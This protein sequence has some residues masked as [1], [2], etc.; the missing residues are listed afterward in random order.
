[1]DRCAQCGA[2][3]DQPE[4]GR[5]RRYC[6]RSCQARAY[7]ARSAARPT[8]RIARPRELTPARIAAAAVALADRTGFEGL[9]MRRLATELGIATMGLYRHFPS[10]D[11][12][13]VAMTDAVLDEVRP[14]G[15]HLTGWRPRL[16]H[17][18]R[19]E[20]ALYRRHPWVLPAIARSRP[21]VGRGLLASVDRILSGI[22][23]LGVGP[24]RLLSVYLAVSGLVQGLALLPAAEAAARA[25]TGEDLAEWWS[26]RGEALADLLAEFPF[27]AERFGPEAMDLDFDALFE[28]GL[29]TLLD[30]LEARS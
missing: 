1:M 27:L 2:R 10:R 5:R 11:A 23:D 21:P 19:E 8:E 7:R 28:F 12:L 24:E 18:A 20:W 22:E 3:I 25:A 29:A 14:P 16:E 4:R 13:V 6:S 30:G 26:R 9:T 17:E 15:P